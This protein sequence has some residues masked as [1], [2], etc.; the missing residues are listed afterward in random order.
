MKSSPTFAKD[1]SFFVQKRKWVLPAGS[2]L[3][4]KK[5]IASLL[6]KQNKNRF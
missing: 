3:A 4:L 6:V 5:L 2:A 1:L